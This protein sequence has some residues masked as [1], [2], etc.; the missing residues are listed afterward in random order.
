MHLELDFGLNDGSNHGM[1]EVFIVVF[2][3]A[4]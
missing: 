1:I 4:K 2:V 3:L